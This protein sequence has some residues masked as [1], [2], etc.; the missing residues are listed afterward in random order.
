MSGMLA[1][2][3]ENQMFGAGFGL[4]SVG[5]AATFA[6]KGFQ[7]SMGFSMDIMFMFSFTGWNGSFPETLHDNCRGYM[8]RQ[9]ISLGPG[10]DCQERSEKNS[11]FVC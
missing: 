10:M 9:I 8:Q 7:V 3:G 11:A 6:R 1:S 5:L 2:L 4:F